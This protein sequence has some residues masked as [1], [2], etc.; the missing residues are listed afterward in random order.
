MVKGSAKMWPDLSIIHGYIKDESRTNAGKFLKPTAA[1]EKSRHPL[2]G[3]LVPADVACTYVKHFLVTAIIVIII[4]II[5]II[6]V[7]VITVVAI[8]IIY[9]KKVKELKYKTL[10][11]YLFILFI[12]LFI[13][14]SI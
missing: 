8:I 2:F 4:I 11:L 5:I 6:I 10:V 14:L 7:N 12:H 1:V 9:L 13:Y 3:R